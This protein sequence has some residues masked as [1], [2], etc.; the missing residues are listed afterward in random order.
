MSHI[1]YTL[2]GDIASVDADYIM[3]SEQIYDKENMLVMLD[4]YWRSY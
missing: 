3:I 4:I 1:I 2:D